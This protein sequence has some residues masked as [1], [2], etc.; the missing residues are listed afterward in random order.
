ML[1]TVR[2]IDSNKGKEM[3]KYLSFLSVCKMLGISRGSVYK[4]V[5]EKKLPARIDEDL[6]SGK[7][8]FKFDAED[9]NKFKELLKKK[10]KKGQSLV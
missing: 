3:S 4:Y 6:M 8:E 2:F 9:V 1:K 5:A 10:R 7:V